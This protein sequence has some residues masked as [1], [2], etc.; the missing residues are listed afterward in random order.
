[1]NLFK[2]FAIT[3]ALTS[4][5]LGSSS[6]DAGNRNRPRP[7][8]GNI[9]VVEGLRTFSFN[10]VQHRDGSVTGQGSLQNRGDGFLDHYEFDC[11]RIVGHTAVISGTLTW[12]KDPSVEGLPIQRGGPWRRTRRCG[13]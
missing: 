2:P 8:H 11:L 5:A 6:S 12:S 4:L 3:V 10:V 7:G 1:M 13:G 9:F